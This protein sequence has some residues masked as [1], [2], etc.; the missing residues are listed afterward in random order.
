MALRIENAEADRLTRESSRARALP[1]R[2]ELSAIRR[3]CAALPI[4]DDRTPDEILGYDE[5]RLP[6]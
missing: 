1:L 5:R 4:L 3:R 6:C 2:E